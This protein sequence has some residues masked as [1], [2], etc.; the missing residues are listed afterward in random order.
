MNMTADHDLNDR[1]AT[2]RAAICAASNKEHAVMDGL[3]AAAIL[4]GETLWGILGV[5]PDGEMTETMRKAREIF[6]LLNEL[7]QETI[8]RMSELD[9]QLEAEGAHIAALGADANPE[10]SYCHGLGWEMDMEGE[11]VPCDECGYEDR[12]DDPGDVVMKEWTDAQEVE[13][14]ARNVAHGHPF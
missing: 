9:E 6:D 13:H 8:D 7:E 1:I 10:C 12:A 14:R 2:A 5:I 4:A 11:L 3:N